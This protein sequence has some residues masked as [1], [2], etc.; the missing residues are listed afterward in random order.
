[1]AESTGNTDIDL[2]MS[3]RGAPDVPLDN[4]QSGF[5]VLLVDV[6]GTPAF[7]EEHGE[8][9]VLVLLQHHHELVV[10]EIEQAGG[11]VVRT[12]G[13]TALVLLATAAEAAQVA[14]RLQ[15]RIEK[16]NKDRPGKEQ[17]ELRVALHCSGDPAAERKAFDDAVTVAG[18]L[19]KACQPSQILLSQALVQALPKEMGFSVGPAEPDAVDAGPVAGEVRELAWKPAV[20]PVEPE[21]PPPVSQPAPH[22]KDAVKPAQAPAAQ[23][24]AE[25]EPPKKLGRYEILEE[26]GVGGMGVVY[27]ANDPTV[28]RI[29]AIKTVRLDVS[30]A[31][32]EELVSRLKQEAQ[33]AGRLEHPAIVTVYDAGEAE[34]VFYIAMQYVEGRALSAYLAERTLLA[35]AQIVA[36]VEECC[37]GLHYAHEQGIIHRDLKPGN[38]VLNPEGRPK[39]LDFGIA[40]ITDSGTT[41]AGVILG[42]PNYMSPEQAA[43][44]RVDRRADIFSL[45]AIL[46]ELLTGERAF[47]GKTAAEVLKKIRDQEPKPIREI[48]ATVEPALERVVRKA[49]VKDPFQRYQNCQAMGEALTAIRAA[50]AA[51]QAGQQVPGAGYSPATVV[52]VPPGGSHPGVAPTVAYGAVPGQAAQVPMPVPTPTP[53]GTG[54]AGSTAPPKPIPSAVQRSTAG[55]VV[56][57]LL[58]LFFYGVL[59]AVAGVAGALWQGWIAPEEIPTVEQL[60]AKLPPS[61]RAQLERFGIVAPEAIRAGASATD[62]PQGAP[63]GGEGQPRSSQAEGQSGA[64]PP[65][66]GDVREGADAGS[67]QGQQPPAPE[68]TG[69]TPPTATGETPGEQ[70]GTSPATTTP[71]TERKRSTR[72]PSRPPATPKKVLS[73]QD[74]ARVKAL[75]DQARSFLNQNELDFAERRGKDVLAID[76]DNE[77]AKQLLAAIEQR[78][79]VPPG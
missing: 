1:M 45:G 55:M 24:T 46:Y 15:Q 8:N 73:P 67:S 21:A 77:E 50:G 51:A 49:L 25:N 32:R 2:L 13:D 20:D 6:I 19:V 48:D 23:P 68:S 22:A 63:A 70:E 40:K 47:S 66:S 29:V 27:K 26:I 11:T 60:A 43:G 76:P 7:F 56:H 78:R 10:P 31:Q 75:L 35:V 79:K 17:F 41:Q 14:I 57:F 72:R 58:A 34:G 4:F 3:S 30:G 54:V 53:S 18:G 37:D 5:A 52:M 28:G 33:A 9:A 44:R 16:F 39:I 61:V 42:T 71:P 74:A 65:G 36:I 64:G 12:I 59:I 69:T 62:T 38:I